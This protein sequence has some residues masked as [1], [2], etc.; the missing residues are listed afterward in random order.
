MLDR[1]VD[2]DCVTTLQHINDYAVVRC[3]QHIVGRVP[4]PCNSTCGQDAFF[5]HRWNIN[6][7]AYILSNYRSRR[8]I[9]THKRLQKLLELRAFGTIFSPICR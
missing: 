6:H 5:L 1:A 8:P 3:H 9:R 7:S 2:G 4:K